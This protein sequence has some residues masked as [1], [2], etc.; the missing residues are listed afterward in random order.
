MG[1]WA[2]ARLSRRQPWK[3]IARL[4]APKIPAAGYR[5]SLVEKSKQVERG[6]F[7]GD[8]ETRCGDRGSKLRLKRR[9]RLIQNLQQKVR[10]GFRDVHRWREANRLSL[11]TAFAEQEAHVL[12]A[13]QD[14][15]ALRFRGLFD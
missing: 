2:S 12:A 15:G 9:E 1:C 8:P 4:T 5:G 13:L 7:G 3:G 14:F 11:Q 6:V 10:V